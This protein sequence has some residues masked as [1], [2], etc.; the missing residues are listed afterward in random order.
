MKQPYLYFRCESGGEHAGPARNV[1][2]GRVVSTSPD[3]ILGLA[4]DGS[5]SKVSDGFCNFI[6]FERKELLAKKIDA[7]T[8]K[9][10]LDVSKHIGAI[11]HF[12]WFAGLWLF[13]P[14][15]GKPA[16]VHYVAAL[17]PDLSIEMRF[18]LPEHLHEQPPAGHD[19][20]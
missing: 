8:A 6:G 15:D 7:I 16:L 19:K 1:T 18:V 17:V 3:W 14:K 5:I 13:L 2:A 11:H 9:R 4:L 20:G 12:G 10:A